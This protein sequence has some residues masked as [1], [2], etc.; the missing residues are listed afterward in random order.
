MSLSLLPGRASHG[1]SPPC[2]IR[3]TTNVIYRCIA[4]AVGHGSESKA[5]AKGSAGDDELDD[6]VLIEVIEGEI[7]PARNPRVA[8]RPKTG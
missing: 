6:D 3:K 1:E 7:V 5:K 2:D 8:R 4:I